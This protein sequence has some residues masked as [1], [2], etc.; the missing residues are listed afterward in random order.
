MLLRCLKG[1]QLAV[2]I[3]T[4][5][6]LGAGLLLPGVM[7]LFMVPLA[8]L[9]VIWVIRAA[10]DHRLSI[11]LSF[12]STLAVAVLLGAFAVSM[13]VSTIEAGD[14][15]DRAIPLVAMDPAGNVVQLPPEALPRLRQVQA[16]IDRRDRVHMSI[17][18]SIGLGAWVVIGLYAF[19][20]RWAFVRKATR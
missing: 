6:A 3:A 8:V 19:E 9:Y 13:A 15:S 17:L 12:A 1:T 10:L 14:A 11:W 20:W 2:A 18:L 4:N 7:G 5:F 16:R